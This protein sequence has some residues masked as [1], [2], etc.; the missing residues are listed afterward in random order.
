MTLAIGFSAE[1]KEEIDTFPKS[2]E[3]K[4]KIDCLGLDIAPL[5]QGRLTAWKKYLN[6][7][8]FLHPRTSLPHI[9]FI[10]SQKKTDRSPSLFLLLLEIKSHLFVHCS[11]FSVSACLHSCKILLFPSHFFTEGCEFF[12]ID[13]LLCL[14]VFAWMLK[15]LLLTVIYVV[16]KYNNFPIRLYIPSPLTLSPSDAVLCSRQIVMNPMSLY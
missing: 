16:R 6:C 12:F 3:D 9:P 8:P 10:T 14:C 2:S 15:L 4:I 1:K 13:D 5:R 7:I 11:C